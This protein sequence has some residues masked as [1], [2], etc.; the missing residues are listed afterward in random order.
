MHV[1]YMLQRIP[2]KQNM[3]IRFRFRA[4]GVIAIVAVFL[5]R[6]GDSILKM[7]GVEPYFWTHKKNGFPLNSLWT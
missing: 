6:S 2:A 4:I 1:I 7:A 5:Y 3:K